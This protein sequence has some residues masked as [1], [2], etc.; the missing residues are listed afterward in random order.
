VLLW[1]AQGFQEGRIRFPP[2][3]KFLPG[4]SA[5][6]EKRV[7]SWTDRILWKVRSGPGQQQQLEEEQQQQ[8]SWVSGQVSRTN[9]G[10][11]GPPPCVTQLYYTS[12]PE[13]TSSDHKPVIAGFEVCVVGAEEEE[14]EEHKSTQSDDEGVDANRSRCCFM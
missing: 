5:Y 7:P 10:V 12:V 6:S 14:S 3:F 4:S 9:G 8:L 1:C 2:T 13:V 11:P